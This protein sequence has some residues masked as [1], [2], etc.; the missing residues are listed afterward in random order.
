MV[1]GKGGQQNF[2]GFLGTIPT[3]R[4]I[5]TPHLV[6]GWGDPPANAD[7]EASA[8][9]MVE[10]GDLLHQPQRRV[11]GQ[12][13]HQRHQAQAGGSLGGRGQQHTL[14][15]GHVERGHVVF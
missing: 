8:G 7:L 14:A 10:H 9:E 2:E 15:R 1:L 4:R 11:E 6:F 3:Q 13:I 5:E 12:Q